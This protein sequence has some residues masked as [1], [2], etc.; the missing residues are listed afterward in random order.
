MSLSN[1]YLARLAAA[2]SLI[3]LS[4][5]AAVGPNFK[6]PEP[7][8]GAAGAGYAM[9]GDVAASAVSLSPE[10]RAAGPWWQ[11]FGSPELDAAVRQALKDSPTLAE[12]RATLERARAIAAES[13]AR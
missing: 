13:R 11:A 5:C 6:R 12:A 10:T 3:A 2:A 8:A 4:A 9:A 7:P 1:R